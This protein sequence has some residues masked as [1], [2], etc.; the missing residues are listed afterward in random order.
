MWINNEFQHYEEAFNDEFL[1][2]GFIIDNLHF[3][4]AMG[5]LFY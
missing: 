1:I 3:K 5:I 4:W 2:K